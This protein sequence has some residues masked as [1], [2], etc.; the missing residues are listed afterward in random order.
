M[1]KTY[2]IYGHQNNLTK[3]WFIG[4]ISQKSKSRWKNGCRYKNNPKF[5]DAINKY[6]WDNFR[7]IIFEEN[8]LEELADERECHYIRLYDSIEN[9]YNLSSNN[10]YLEELK[11]IMSESRNEPKSFSFS[12]PSISQ[13][14]IKSRI[15][16]QAKSNDSRRVRCVETKETFSSIAEA[17]IKADIKNSSS[18]SS[19]CSNRSK[20]AAGYHWEYAD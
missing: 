11:Q 14:K 17:A 18:I 1:E 7:H 13:T 20:T 16:K 3:I 5:L 2:I 19:C 15:S 9:G 10:E 6:G 8:V 4:R 12:L